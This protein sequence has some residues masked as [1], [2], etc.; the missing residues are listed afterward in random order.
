[1][2]PV[3]GADRVIAARDRGGL[4]VQVG[5]MKRFDP[6]YEALLDDCPPSRCDVLHVASATYDPGL[7]R[8]VRARGAAAAAPDVLSDVFLGALVHDVNLVPGCSSGSARG[9]RRAWSTRSRGRGRAAGGTVVGGGARWSLAGCP[10]RARRL[11]RGRSPSTRRDG[12]REPRRSRRRTCAGA[13][14]YARSAGP[15]RRQRAHVPARG[16]E[17]YDASSSTSTRASRAARRA[18]RRRAARADVA[19]LPTLLRAAV[20][21]A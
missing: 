15:R 4:V 21:V 2:P 20:A 17:A 12:V 9:P 10:G 1:M 11:P 5:Y 19:L 7:A 14:G 18:G 6:A 3:E 8:A 16:R 13:D